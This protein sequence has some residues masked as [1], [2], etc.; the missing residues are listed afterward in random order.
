MAHI[1]LLAIYKMV[2]ERAIVNTKSHYVVFSRLEEQ[3]LQEF[4][5]KTY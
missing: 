3:F 2:T 4:R 5:V 1:I